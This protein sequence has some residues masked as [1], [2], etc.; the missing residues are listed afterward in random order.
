MEVGTLILSDMSERAKQIPYDI[1][2]I[3]NN[4]WHKWN[5]LQERNKLMDLENRLVIVKREGKGLGGTGS[6]GLVD[7]NYWTG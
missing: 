4:M 2:Y 1:T 5:Y 7:A 3:C 6:L